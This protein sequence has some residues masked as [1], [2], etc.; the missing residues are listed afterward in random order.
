MHKIFFLRKSTQIWG[1]KTDLSK[2]KVNFEANMVLNVQS[3][4]VLFGQKNTI[5]G[6][7]GIQEYGNTKKNGNTHIYMITAIWEY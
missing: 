3:H 7:T 4:S 2:K 1:D 6:Y 5:Q